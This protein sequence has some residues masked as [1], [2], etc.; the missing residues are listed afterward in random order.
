MLLFAASANE[1]YC[2]FT[3]AN[4]KNSQTYL[5]GL[6]QNQIPQGSTMVN[7][8]T[9]WKTVIQ[10]WAWFYAVCVSAP[11]RFDL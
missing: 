2:V 4:K 8:T 10:Q 5:L 7:V 6:S 11:N 9:N 3:Y 1:G